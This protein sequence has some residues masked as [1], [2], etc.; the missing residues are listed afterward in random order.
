[1]KK[2]C[3]KSGDRYVSRNW[4]N[5]F[6]FTSDRHKTVTYDEVDKDK[7]ENIRKSLPYLMGKHGVILTYF[8][9]DEERTIL[10]NNEEYIENEFDIEKIKDSFDDTFT[11]DVNTDIYS[12]DTTVD[13]TRLCNKVKDLSEELKMVVKLR[14]TTSERLS[15]ADLELSDILHYIE[16]YKF[17]ASEA[18]KLCKMLQETLDKR[19]N[20]KY[21]YELCGLLGTQTCKHIAEGKTEQLFN[22]RER[23]TYTPKVLTELFK[24]K[25]KRRRSFN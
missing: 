4:N 8:E 3:L 15:H 2:Y 24:D 7:L 14:E 20:I 12:I 9:T 5:S 1:M 11:Y 6:S 17:S 18:W 16:F 22:R 25:E 10:K 21:E 23:H 13:F 19:R